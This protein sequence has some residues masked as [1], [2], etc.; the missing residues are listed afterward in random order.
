MAF[1]P[2]NLGMLFAERAKA[3][4]D[5]AALRY[6]AGEISYDGLVAQVEQLAAML[7]RHGYS[8][9]DVIAIAHNKAALSYALMLAALRLGIVYVNIDTASPPTR[10]GHILKTSG[11]RTLFVDDLDHLPAMQD[12][13]AASGAYAMLLSE[14]EL[15]PVNEEGLLRQATAM[16]EVD[17]ACIAYIMFTSGSTG[18]PKGVAVTHQNVLHFIQWGIERFDVGYNDNFANLSP[19]YFDNS[20]F[21]FYVALFS[22]ASLT[23]VHRKLLNAPSALV[24]HVAR[25]GCTIWFSVPS[26]LIYV[27]TMKALT[28]ASLP[29]IRCIIFGGEGYPKVELIKLYRM[30][31]RQ[32]KLV[33]VYGPTECTCI[34]SAY[35][36]SDGDF[37]DMTGLPTLGQLNPNFDH[38]IFDDDGLEADLG[39]LCLIG[40]NVASGY[41]NDPERSA[42]AFVT[43][44]DPRRFMKRMYRTGDLV[45]REAGQLH[46]VGRKD[47]Q[48]K[49]MGYRIELEEIEHGLAKIPGVI[50][51]AVIY[52]RAETAFGKLIGFVSSSEAL[53][54]STLQ[55]QLAEHVPDYMIPS[56]VI[57]IDHLPKSP[58]G[59]VDRQ[60]LVALLME[61]AN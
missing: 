17:G 60:N 34:C 39:E 14:A 1:Y 35:V 51:A 9:G 25:M 19:M 40:P 2:Y 20:V 53:D 13:A 22:G 42:V 49:H 10:N 6:P 44:T 4:G 12:L 43:L 50:Q 5:R 7:L 37:T 45:R 21:D 33:N 48:I 31:N 36:L 18:M 56:R 61:R 27:A 54:E 16:A 32:A 41:F 46:F 58:N 23:P 52:H 3:A 57:V 38:L 29:T 55:R 11:A 47:N 15:E 30:F 26:L 8:R 28:A 24:A 59:K